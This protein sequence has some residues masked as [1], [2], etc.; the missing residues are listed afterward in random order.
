MREAV[1]AEARNRGLSEDLQ[2]LRILF[3]GETSFESRQSQIDDPSFFLAPTGARDPQA[4]LDATILAI[5]EGTPSGVEKSTVQCR[6]PARWLWLKTKFPGRQ[7]W[8]EIHCPAFAEFQTRVAAKSASLVFSSYYV[9]NPASSFGHTFLRLNKGPSP[10]DGR[11]HELLDYG[12]NYAANPTTDN[13]LLYTFAGLFGYFE[14]VFTS[15]PYFHKVREYNDFE[16]RDLW[17]YDLNL[18]AQAVDF[19]VALIWELAPTKIN[20]WY[21]TENCS[22]HMLSIL[23]A[24]DPKLD[25]RRNLKKWI[26]PVDTLKAVTEVPD[27][28]RRIHFR[29]SASTTYF[30]SRSQLN[31][32]ERDALFRMVLQRDLT[33]LERV[34]SIQ[35]RARVL[36]VAFDFLDYTAFEKLTAPTKSAGEGSAETPEK[37]LKDRLLL[38]RARIDLGPQL[39]RAPT[40]EFEAPHLAHGSRRTGLGVRV[41]RGRDVEPTFEYRFSLHGLEDPISGFPRDSEIRFFDFGL[42][43]FELNLERLLLLEVVS[44]SETRFEDPK[45]S[46]MLRVGFDRT[47]FG[48]CDQR[49]SNLVIA[50]SAGQT[51][52]LLSS[53]TISGQMGV[54]VEGG[55]PESYRVTASGLMASAG[56]EIRLRTIWNET[57]ISSLEGQVEFPTAPLKPIVTFKFQ[58]QGMISKNFALSLDAIEVLER[59]STEPH[60]EIT[61]S[62]R[63]FY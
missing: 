42:K 50:G 63:Y 20:Y 24:A 61:S 34:S 6:Y 14:G 28:V 1:L 36:E 59:D 33:A 46:W 21:L 53:T 52:R 19:L 54:S 23:D 32:I 18:D 39:M 58:T 48:F 37:V 45:I 47:R 3:Y 25:L 11:S 35:S 12:I 30:S 29:P 4:E 10:K 62:I 38:E 7:G 2:W 31:A 5:F 49:C 40:P 60:Q 41:A 8:P 56:P 26:V 13:P 16:S 57:L 51:Y 9:N 17:S 15:V 55:S 27:L 22:Y 44:L 43:G